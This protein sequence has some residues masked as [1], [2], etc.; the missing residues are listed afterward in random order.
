MA[1]ATKM[2][3]LPG[4]SVD[5]AALQKAIS[6]G[7]SPEEALKEAVVRKTEPN[8]ISA[9]RKA[10]LAEKEKAAKK[11]DDGLSSEKPKS[12]PASKPSPKGDD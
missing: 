10:R 1:E 2:P 8:P 11:A 4:G 9:A 7:K 5:A 3:P 12:A 6:S